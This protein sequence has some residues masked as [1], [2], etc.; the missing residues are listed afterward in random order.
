ML[1]YW[2]QYKWIIF[3]VQTS[4]NDIQQGNNIYQHTVKFIHQI[5]IKKFRK[6]KSLVFFGFAFFFCFFVWDTNWPCVWIVVIATEWWWC[7][8]GG[9]CESDWSA[10][11]CLAWVFFFLPAGFGGALGA[12]ASSGLSSGWNTTVHLSKRISSASITSRSKLSGSSPPV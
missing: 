9:W 6:K 12:A 5:Y 1:I 4:Y 11:C 3:F 10:C 8:F 2:M 7:W